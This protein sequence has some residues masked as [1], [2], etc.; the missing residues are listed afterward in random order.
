MVCTG[1]GLSVDVIT[2]VE[3]W[4]FVCWLRNSQ[5][6]TSA[7]WLDIKYTPMFYTKS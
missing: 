6:A 5:L 7:M 3:E 1:D 2:H 4:K